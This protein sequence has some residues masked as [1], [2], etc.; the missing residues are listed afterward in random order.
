M[1]EYSVGGV[2]IVLLLREAPVRQSIYAVLAV[3]FLL[4][5]ALVAK[6]VMDFSHSGP[7]IASEITRSY[8]GYAVYALARLGLWAFVFIGLM[9]GAGAVAYHCLLTAFR[10][11]H[12]WWM[13]A[14]SAGLSVGVITAVQFIHFLLYFPGGI[15]ASFSY[16][17]NRLYPVWEV[18]TPARVA[19]L[20]V[21]TA[22]MFAV[23]VLLAVWAMGRRGEGKKLMLPG[24]VVAALGVGLGV[25][26]WHD[27]G[28]ATYRPEKGQRPNII[29]IG[30]DTLRADRL[31]VNGYARNL[32]PNID[33][34]A[35]TG[36]NFA[37]HLVPIGR[38]A[39]SL[40]S[41]LTGLWPHSH[42]VRDN[43]VDA[44]EFRVFEDALPRALA[45]AGYRTAVL[46]DW[47]GSDLGKFD[48]GFDVVDTSP[49]QWNLKYLLRQGPKDIRLF[50]SLFT[51]NRLGK[52]L[53]PEVYF[54]AGMPLTTE[55]G[56]DARA[57]IGGLSKQDAPFFL[58]IFIA[59][60]HGPFSSAYPYYRLYGD[61][62]YRG[63]SL[64]SMSDVSSIEDV[65][66]AQEAGRQHFDVQQ[67]IDV[68]DGAVKSFDDEV[69]KLLRYLAQTGLDQNTIVVIY[70]DHGV[71]L[72]EGETWGQ[73]NIV[74]DFSHRVPLIIFDPRRGPAGTITRTVRSVDVAPTILE[75][76]GLPIPASIEGT[77]LLPYWEHG[78]SLPDRTAFAETGIWIAK[79]RG[80]PKNRITYPLV[81][82]LLEIPDKQTGTLA[83]KP[84][85]REIIVRAKSLLAR[86]GRWA[87][88]Y[89]PLQRAE[90]YTLHDIEKDLAMRHNVIT[91]H[92][93]IAAKLKAQLREWIN[94][95]RGI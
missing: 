42:G 2:R 55:V 68:Y 53:L 34:L 72:F 71:D 13:A 3:S 69:G 66:K 87:L 56:R 58:N 28:A 7:Q 8:L 85:Y 60:T 44:R 93:E 78:D 64:F 31:G 39:P 4:A 95:G 76:S 79:V 6:S 74:S 83:I 24:A 89:F 38:T 48:L 46:G 61:P 26:L 91:D 88:V 19:M 27:S 15:V 22:T 70:S 45:R 84:Q 92:P 25:T 67:I 37:Q 9:A 62:A 65:L 30:S 90:Q 94:D 43:Y 35:A 73:G 54:L 17:V 52:Y 80:L 47:A 59:A 5:L 49:D 63:D 81:L 32:T 51:H 36:I 10:W 50:L 12:R 82:D 21:G 29:M 14:I 40:L 16:R 77:S 18:L 75:L 41:L 23:P 86:E 20:E 57:L 33:R 11:R 1:D